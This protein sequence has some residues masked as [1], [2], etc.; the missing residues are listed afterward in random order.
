MTDS[1]AR[2]GNAPNPLQRFVLRHSAARYAKLAPG[3]REVAIERDLFLA[4]PRA[5]GL[6]CGVVCG[7][8]GT[9]AGLALGSPRGL[10]ALSFLVSALTFAGFVM[11]G[12]NVWLRPERFTARRL[13]RITW[14]S[15][16]ATYAGALV[17][18]GGEARALLSSGA[19][20]YEAVLR[21]AWRATPAQ[22]TLLVAALSLMAIVAAA[23]RQHMQRALAEAHLE[24]ERDAA[25]RQ[26]AQ[27]R[28]ALLQAQIQP[29]FLFNTLAALQHW[30]DTGDARAPALLRALTAFL[31]GS[32]ELMLRDEVTLAQDAEQVRHYLDIMRARLG[33]RL[34]YRIDVPVDCAEQP[35]PPGIL[36]TLVENAIEHGIEPLLRG[37]E[38]QVAAQRTAEGFALRVCDDGAGLAADVAGEVDATSGVGLA[39]SRER[40][41]HRF[42]EAAS[43]RL[44]R[45][46]DGPGAEALLFLPRPS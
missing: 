28:L 8:A 3:L 35:L 11:I 10:W 7:T 27:A 38:V 46:S 5:I 39:N 44:T 30:V 25:A 40:L 14:I 23:R 19:P 4:S 33:D 1:N 32:T 37:G 12:M 45:R 2:P 24:Q 41:R 6:W 13:R 20:W 42:G 17:S 43:L 18:F 29:H 16:V 9:T 26:V 34:R 36:I 15:L 21:V 31:R 22:I